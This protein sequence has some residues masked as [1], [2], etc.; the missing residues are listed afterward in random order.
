VSW[1]KYREKPSVSLSQVYSNVEAHADRKPVR[2][3]FRD[4]PLPLTLE[5]AVYQ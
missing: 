3:K 2:I 1:Y 4:V 5:W